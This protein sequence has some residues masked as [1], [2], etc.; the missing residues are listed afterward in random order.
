MQTH[1]HELLLV[2]IGVKDRKGFLN[3]W[4]CETSRDSS[5][6][7]ALSGLAQQ[8]EAETISSLS[9]QTILEEESDSAMKC[10]VENCLGSSF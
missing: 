3:H 4:R 6:T 10:L 9:R 5:P 7:D 1:A 8:Y 2:L